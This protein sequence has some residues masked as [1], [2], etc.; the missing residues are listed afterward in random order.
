VC[1]APPEYKDDVPAE[2]RARLNTLAQRGQ[3]YCPKPPEGLKNLVG[4]VYW[5]SDGVDS[6]L[7]FQGTD[8]TGVTVD[9]YGFGQDYLP[10]PR[11]GPPPVAF[12][13]TSTGRL[14]YGNQAPPGS[15]YFVLTLGTPADSD[16]AVDV[17]ISGPATENERLSGRNFW[18][19]LERLTHFVQ[20]QPAAQRGD[21]TVRVAVPVLPERWIAGRRRLVAP[22]FAR[23]AQKGDTE[24]VPDFGKVRA[25]K[26]ERP[27]WLQ[28]LNGTLGSGVWVAGVVTGTTPALTLA[29][30][31][32]GAPLAAQGDA[33]RWATTGS[34]MTLASFSFPPLPQGATFEARYWHDQRRAA[35]APPDVT[36][37]VVAP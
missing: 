33:Q 24:V 28:T 29:P 26:L 17:R 32:G 1:T 5:G 8:M 37:P 22:E 4:P 34:P 2:L 16:V 25:A 7:F 15:R 19:D 13:N 11:G 36:F 14:I 9:R 35:T 30:R 12:R 6:I 18:R 10:G 23:A 27:T 3:L 21:T 31:A 20:G